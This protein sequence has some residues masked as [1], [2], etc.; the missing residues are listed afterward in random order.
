[1]IAPN[2]FHPRKRLCPVAGCRQMISP[3]MAMCTSHWGV[4]PSPM[5]KAVID[6]YRR[7]GNGSLAHRTALEV[8][9]KAIAPKEAQ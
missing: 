1:M 2:Q 9:L 3:S 7:Y 8:A 4:V 5:R 6:A